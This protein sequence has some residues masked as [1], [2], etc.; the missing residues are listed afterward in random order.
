MVTE[1][2]GEVEAD[3]AEQ[4][5]AAAHCNPEALP[6]HSHSQILLQEATVQMQIELSIL[7]CVRVVT[8]CCLPSGELPRLNDL[9]DDFSADVTIVD[10]YKCTWTVRFMQYVAARENPSEM[11][12]LYRRW[13]FNAAT[14]M[15]AANGDLESLQW[16]MEKY[17]PD[18]FLTKAVAVATTN[19][20]LSILQWLFENHHDR[21]YW[22]HTEMCG[23][24]THGHTEV[25]EWLR[26]HAVPRAE[27]SVRSALSN[28][29]SHRQREISQWILENGE[30]V[31]PWINWDQPAKDGALTFLKFLHSHSIGSPGYFTLQSAAS[32]GHL[33]IVKWLHAELG[34]TLTAD[35]MRK[36]AQ[37]GHLGVVEWFHENG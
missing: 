22:G 15:T 36:A 37:N 5:A 3:P 26:E 35:A 2:R 12:V 6:A 23:A 33:D 7:T 27:L 16:L 21:G 13:L 17:L 1:S 9:L 30:L 14:E 19:G 29:M 10:A 20:H 25:V 4:S 32:N 24:L 34:A 31:M 18:E 28:A 11:N 8:R